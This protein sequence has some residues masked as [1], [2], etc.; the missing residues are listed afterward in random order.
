MWVITIDDNLYYAG[1]TVKGGWKSCTHLE[2]AVQ[3][4]AFY[5]ALWDRDILQFKNRNIFRVRRV[6]SSM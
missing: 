1:R 4:S 6:D 5:D 2:D 3:Y